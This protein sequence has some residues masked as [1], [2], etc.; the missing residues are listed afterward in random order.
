MADAESM[1][2][3]GQLPDIEADQS[4]VRFTPESGH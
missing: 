2:A 4:Y 1:S 3:L